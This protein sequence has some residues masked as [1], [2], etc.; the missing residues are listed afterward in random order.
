[1]LS[2]LYAHAEVPDRDAHLM[3]RLGQQLRDTID[4]GTASL[5]RIAIANDAGAHY[6]LVIIFGHVER[7]RAVELLIQLGYRQGGPEPERGLDAVF[8]PPGPGA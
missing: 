6:R 1:M 2:T 7:G 4:H 5:Y 3:L 8:H